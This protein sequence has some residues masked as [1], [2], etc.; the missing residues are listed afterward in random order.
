MRLMR[1]R[2]NASYEQARYHSHAGLDASARQPRTELSATKLLFCLASYSW[3]RL[4]AGKESSSILTGSIGP[5][6]SAFLWQTAWFYGSGTGEN[7]MVTS[8]ENPM[9]C[10]HVPRPNF[11]SWQHLVLALCS[12]APGT[13]VDTAERHSPNLHWYVP[14]E[15]LNSLLMY[16]NKCMLHVKQ[17]RVLDRVKWNL[18]RILDGLKSGNLWSISLIDQIPDTARAQMGFLRSVH[19][20]ISSKK[21]W[22]DLSKLCSIYIYSFSNIVILCQSTVFL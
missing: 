19:H 22:K 9:V 6:H 18:H 14:Q 4:K 15:Q 7:P 16:L 20:Q 10:H 1:R 5:W 13:W 17:K 8:P 2:S 11:R 12:S 21:R 3:R